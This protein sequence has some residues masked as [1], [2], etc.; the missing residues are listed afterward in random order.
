MQ[1]NDKAEKRP[2]K[3]RQATP[4]ERDKAT[5]EAVK[6]QDH[7]LCLVLL[8]PPLRTYIRLVSTDMFS[9][10]AARSL[11]AF[12]E[13]HPDFEGDVTGA[14]ELR[15]ISDYVKILVLQYEELY[16]G[17]EHL[18]LQY[19]AARLQTRVV[20]QFV[21]ITKQKLVIQLG[22]ANEDTTQTL[23]G[24]VKQLDLLLKQA[25]GGMNG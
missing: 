1:K 23:L 11:V 25:K 15:P 20:E 12:L 10:E 21:K 19:E 9:E 14:Q 24:R 4:Q 2:L 13:K 5:V 6:V 18:E 22:D 17:L 16:Q 3:R 8:H 7:L